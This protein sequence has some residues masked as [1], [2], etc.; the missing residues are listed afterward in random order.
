M[1][2][3]QAPPECLCQLY[4]DGLSG[5]CMFF[6]LYLFRLDKEDKLPAHEPVYVV[7]V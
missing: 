5:Y 4:F 7:Y 2:S 1:S 6:W 3:A